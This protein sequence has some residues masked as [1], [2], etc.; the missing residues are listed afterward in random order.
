LAQ[1]MHVTIPESYYLL[2]IIYNDGLHWKDNEA[3]IAGKLENLTIKKMIK[4]LS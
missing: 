2:G 1:A 3:G 4:E